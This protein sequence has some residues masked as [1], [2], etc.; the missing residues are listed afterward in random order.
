MDM[1]TWVQ[2]LD[3]VIC[4]YHCTNALWRGMVLTI[5]SRYGQ[6]AGQTDLLSKLVHAEELVN[7]Y[8]H[9]LTLC[10]HWIQ[11]RGPTKSNEWLGWME[12]ERERV[13]VCVCIKGPRAISKTWWLLLLFR[14][15]SDFTLL[16]KLEKW[17][18]AQTIALYAFSLHMLT[19]LS[20]DEIL[21]PRYTN[22]FIDFKGSPLKVKVDPFCL[23]HTNTVLFAF[24]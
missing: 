14:Y 19:L 9:T 16:V 10:R 1:A 13:C 11:S 17:Q 23:K 5:P 6:I 2:I 20:V 4:I 7:K 15:H 12:R 21:L 3:E 18:S 22:R 8:I 24:M